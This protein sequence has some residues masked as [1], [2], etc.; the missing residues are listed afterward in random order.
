MSAGNVFENDLAKHIFQNADIALVGDA[1]GLRGSTVAGSLYLALHTADPGEGGD[2][3]TN[4][5]VYSPYARI[6]V[7]RSASGWTVT[8]S[9]ITNAAAIAFAQCSS[10]SGTATYFSIGVA[11]SGPSKIIVSGPLSP[12]IAVSFG[13]TP[14]FGI[15]EIS[16]AI[17]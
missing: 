8:G 11:G 15:G 17:D 4:E 14:T 9:V 10:G 1:T 5:I 12:N 16:G 3:Q 13:V 6:G 7:V 2:Q